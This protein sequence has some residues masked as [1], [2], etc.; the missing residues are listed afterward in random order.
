MSGEQRWRLRVAQPQRLLECFVAISC[1]PTP[2]SGGH[3]DSRQRE[4]HCDDIGSCEKQLPVEKLT[5]WRRLAITAQRRSTEL[6]VRSSEDE[7]RTDG[8]RWDACRVLQCEVCSSFSSQS[9]H[10]L[11][12]SQQT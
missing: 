2:H 11:T 8:I 9:S 12:A 6:S 1:L 7:R 3:E 4:G 10:S 5:V